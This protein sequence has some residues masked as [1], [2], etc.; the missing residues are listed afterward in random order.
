MSWKP[1]FAFVAGFVL[2]LGLSHL[3]FENRATAAPAPAP[4]VGQFQM[5]RMPDDLSGFWLVDTASGHVWSKSK[6]M[7]NGWTDEGAHP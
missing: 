2:S 4:A 6:A 1:T 3:P 5:V 7:G